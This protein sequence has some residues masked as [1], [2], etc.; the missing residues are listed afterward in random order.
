MHEAMC[1]EKGVSLVAFSDLCSSMICEE[2][3]EKKLPFMSGI[4]WC[5]FSS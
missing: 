2:R 5:I 3:E 4:L 1:S